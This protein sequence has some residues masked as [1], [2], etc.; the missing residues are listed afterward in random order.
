[1]LDTLTGLCYYGVC[2]IVATW[3]FCALMYGFTWYGA[4]LQRTTVIFC[5]V[6]RNVTA[7]RRDHPPAAALDFSEDCIN[8]KRNK[9]ITNQ[10]RK[11]G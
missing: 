9:N 4:Q 5:F 3:A 1:M 11:Q 7:S 10:I 2:T 8:N 6:R